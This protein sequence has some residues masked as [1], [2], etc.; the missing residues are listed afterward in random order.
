[1]FEN[2]IGLL[3][4]ADENGKKFLDMM[5]EGFK[6]AGYVVDHRVINT[7]KLGVP[8]ARK[9]VIIIGQRDVEKV[10]YPAICGTEFAYTVSDMFAG[11]PHMKA[12]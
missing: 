5:K 3:S 2:V 8:Q 9:R 4:A 12:G 6:A 7:K 11:L 1:M 10:E